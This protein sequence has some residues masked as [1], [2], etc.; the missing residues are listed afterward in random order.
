MPTMPDLIQPNRLTVLTGALRV[1]IG[2][3]PTPLLA[4]ALQQACTQLNP[5]RQVVVLH[6]PP[7]QAW[8]TQK[9]F[10]FWP[11]S[12]PLWSE[13]T[14]RRLIHMRPGLVVLPELSMP[15]L[16]PEKHLRMH[17]NLTRL[18]AEGITVETSMPILAF[19]QTGD[20]I[21]PPVAWPSHAALSGKFLREYASDYIVH[22]IALEQLSSTIRQLPAWL[23]VHATTLAQ[24][25]NLS[26]LR[27]MMF[28]LVG[29]HVSDLS[30]LNNPG[31]ANLSTLSQPD[32]FEWVG[33]GW[34]LGVGVVAIM[35]ISFFTYLGLAHGW[36]SQTAAGLLLLAVPVV[37]G[38]YSS[39][40]TTFIL[41]VLA[42]FSFTFLFAPSLLVLSS[43]NV[44]EVITVFIFLL[45]SVATSFLASQRYQRNRRAERRAATTQ[46]MLRLAYDLTYA[47]DLPAIIQS[48]L[49]TLSRTLHWQA[50]IILT[51]RQPWQTY[52]DYDL[53][54]VEMA[55]VNTL[56][57]TRTIVDP[58]P[59]QPWLMCPLRV[60][61]NVLGALA[62]HTSPKANY[63]SSF[64]TINMVR[65]YSNLVA[66]ALR[67]H[68]L[69]S[70]SH[71]ANLQAQRESLRS[72]LLAAVSH[73]L[74]SPLV[75]II[76]S[77]STLK[78]AG[79]KLTAADQDELISA[80]LTEAEHLHKIIH[81]VLEITKL[82]SGQIVPNRELVSIADLIREST[83]RMQR[84]YHSFNVK[85]VNANAVNPMVW[86]DALLL[87]QVINNL[88]ENALKYADT[89]QPITV[90][91]QNDEEADAIVTN[92]ADHGPGIPEAERERVFDKFYRVSQ[93]DKRT[94]G[95]GLGLAICRAIV[96][97]HHGRLTITGRPDGASGANI[98]LLLPQAKVTN[99]TT[100]ESA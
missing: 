7:S 91:F 43:D 78:I 57:Q 82:E 21:R 50:M 93:G 30:R 46:A 48:S 15:G 85:I 39:F 52:P 47:E 68:T 95:S 17:R 75:S 42:S 53:T 100:T 26:R 25:A 19:Q 76:G 49:H 69:Q 32:I 16:S 83:R 12:K 62:I 58:T 2:I 14:V 63:T 79:R 31:L 20:V 28:T 72:T 8:T 80:A 34:R 9:N 18:L 55:A 77:L 3:L 90:S 71:S 10:Q 73:D 44:L 23:A 6:T 70:E 67:R 54:P 59:T 40:A 89:T 66:G 61:E 13:A 33:F 84:L 1:H 35:L 98:R 65:T 24:P 41:S 94:A 22:D 97:S 4:Q 56:L 60:G 81:N 99:Q 64:P 87:G 86:G 38:L 29:D 37:T 11:S 92:I 74:K 45:M 96:Q 36:I 5:R 51:E 27:E 88:M